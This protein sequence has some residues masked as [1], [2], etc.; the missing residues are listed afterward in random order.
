MFEMLREYLQENGK[1]YHNFQLKYITMDFEEGL[2][3]A[4]CQT[5]QN[6]KIRVIGSLFHYYQSLTR[7]G[8]KIRN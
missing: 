7:E 1:N 4:C 3:K 2:V 6:E 5:F 8:K